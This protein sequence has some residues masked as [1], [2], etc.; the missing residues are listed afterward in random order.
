MDIAARGYTNPALLWSPET[1]KAG[2]D[3]GSVVVVDT[4]RAEDFANGHIAGAFHFDPYF[5]NC[6]DTD[7]APLRSFTRMWAEMLA[8]RGVN[9][10]DTIVL[11]GAFSD[12]CAARA[13]W[14]IEYLGHKDVHVLDGGMRSWTAAGLP[15]VQG[16]EAPKP[17]KFKWHQQMETVGSYQTVL[18]AIDNPDWVI[19]DNRGPGEWD[20]SEDRAKQ[21][22]HVPSAQHLNWVE[23]YDGETGCYKDADA[24]RALF[25]SRGAT[26][27][28]KIVCYCNTGYRSAHAYLALRLLGH[29]E[30]R[31]YVGSWQE[32]GNRDGMP[33]VI[34][35]AG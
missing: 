23:L 14:F 2:L 21:N 7:P 32:W 26:P 4:R 30:V 5:C 24:L 12:N 17:G 29:P 20:G 10:G 11:Y 33:V 16:A 1:L 25:D 34:P 28:K 31:N 35:P 15:L 6:D 22:G 3:E 9:D 13:W 8:W 27:D 19:L 18:D